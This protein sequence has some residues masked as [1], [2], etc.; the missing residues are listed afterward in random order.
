LYDPA[1]LTGSTIERTKFLRPEFELVANEPLGGL[2]RLHVYFNGG[3]QPNFEQNKTDAKVAWLY[4]V[5]YG[6]R[7]ELGPV[8]LAG[9]GHWGKGLGLAY[10][11]L[12]SDAVY[13]EGSNLRFT[14]GY[15]GMLQLALGK[16]D[17]NAGYGQ[18]NVRMTTLDLTAVAGTDQPPFSWIH[19]QAGLSA[20]LVFHVRPWLHFAADYFRADSKWNLGERQLINFINAGTTVTW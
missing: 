1:M 12:P 18:T 17:V 20:A 16:F 4:G 10:P 3:A 11:G 19:T 5:G 15:F 2:G 14:D 9:G 7:L 8:H 6:A 13:D